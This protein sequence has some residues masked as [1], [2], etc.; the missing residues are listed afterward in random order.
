MARLRVGIIFACGLLVGCVGGQF[1]GA[2]AGLFSDEMARPAPSLTGEHRLPPLS[3]KLEGPLTLERAV[4]IALGANYSVL[5]ARKERDSAEGQITEAR[6]A[7]LPIVG[8]RATYMRMDEVPTF[9]TTPFG[10]P[11]MMDMGVLNN[12]SAALTLQQPI[13][14]GGQARGARRVAALHREAVEEQI[15]AAE[16]GVILLV[17]KQF[18]DAVLAEEDLKAADEALDIARHHVEDVKRKLGQGMATKFEVTR[19]ETRLGLAQAGAILARNAVKLART[20]LLTLLRLPLDGKIK[21][22][23]ALTFSP[24]EVDR[25]G[26]VETALNRRPDLARQETLIRM[27]REKLGITG[28][29]R[30]PSVIITG[31]AGYDDPSQK[32]FGSMDSDT[33]W[34]VGLVVNVPVFDGLRTKGKL[35]QD[36]ARLAQIEMARDQLVDNIRL[37]VTQA[38]LNLRDAEEL[39][40]SQKKIL[41]QAREALRLAQAGYEEGVSRQLDILDAQHGLTEARRGYARAIYAHLMAKVALEKAKGTLNIDLS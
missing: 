21:I 30:R 10:G 19:A 25:E 32:S 29:G 16:Q 9:D 26:A 18:Y 41:G 7:A 11:G 2:A 20:S 3:R 8:L 14:L 24:S 5:M 13:Y 34:R 12:Y 4:E 22:K 39:V 17:H 6:S 23:G 35:R 36:H 40:T 1:D 31:E 15:G 37:E 33:Y 28:A 27:Q 38:L